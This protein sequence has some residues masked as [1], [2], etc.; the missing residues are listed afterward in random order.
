MIA[1]GEFLMFIALFQLE[2]EISR[3]V[4]LF[5]S[6]L[7]LFASPIAFFLAYKSWKTYINP[8]TSEFAKPEFHNITDLKKPNNANS[9]DINS[10][11]ILEKEDEFRKKIV[12][13]IGMY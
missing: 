1:V 13:L 8:K 4:V 7:F 9:Q 12:F 5:A 2:D 10:E 11:K 6:F 3:K